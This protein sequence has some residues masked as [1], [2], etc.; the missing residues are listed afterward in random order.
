[1]SK[2]TRRC[3]C[4]KCGS[5]FFTERAVKTYCTETCRKAAEA[6]RRWQRKKENR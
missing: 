1:M 5:V 4:P 6:S 3:R 2:Q